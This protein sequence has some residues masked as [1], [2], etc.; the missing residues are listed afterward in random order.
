SQRRH[1]AAGRS[2]CLSR[3]LPSPWAAENDTPATVLIAHEV[4]STAFH[5]LIEDA[6]DLAGR[7]GA[8]PLSERGN[9]FLAI[10]LLGRHAR[11]SSWTST[12]ARGIARLRYTVSSSRNSMP[13]PSSAS[14]MRVSAAI[15]PDGG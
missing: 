14:T 1:R 3:S 15:E 2:N 6:L 9:G 4:Q 13:A 5:P 8:M 7:E 12:P 11:A 10:D